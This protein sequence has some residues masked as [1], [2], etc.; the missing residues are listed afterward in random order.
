MVSN[1]MDTDKGRYVV[2]K[3]KELIVAA[4]A[5]DRFVVSANQKGIRSGA[6]THLTFGL[7]E[8]AIRHFHKT[9]SEKVA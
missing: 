6:N 5:E 7:F 1:M 9:L 3:A 8:G 2:D 4:K